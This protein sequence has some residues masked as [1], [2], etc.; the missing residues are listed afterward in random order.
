MTR[1]TFLCMHIDQIIT[2]ITEAC[3]KKTLSPCHTFSLYFPLFSFTHNPYTQIRVYS[4]VFISRK[5]MR[6]RER[7]GGSI[8]NSNAYRYS[9]YV[10][11]NILFHFINKLLTVKKMYVLKRE[12]QLDKSRFIKTKN[13]RQNTSL[14]RRQSFNDAKGIITS[15]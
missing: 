10:R 5:E 2:I 11:Q 9:C 12:T 7:Q 6:L 4:Y 8:L 14:I 13:K 3:W 1:N 15:R